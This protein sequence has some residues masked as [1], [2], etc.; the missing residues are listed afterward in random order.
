MD[1]FSKKPWLDLYGDMPLKLNPKRDTVL[2]LF[3]DAAESSP[4]SIAAI[5]FD[6]SLSYTEL[7]RTSEALAAHLV[8]RGVGQGDRVAII[9]QNDPQFLIGMLAAWKVGAVP[10]PMNPMYRAGE[11]KGLFEDCTP[12]AI[13][14]YASD[15]GVVQEAMDAASISPA[16]IV[17]DPRTYQSRNDERVLPPP[18]AL[19]AGYVSFPEALSE[20]SGRAIPRL[21]PA[22]HEPGLL[23]YTSGTTGKPK[24]A[25]S[26]HFA[27]A[28]NGTSLG[29][30]C[31]LSR[32]SRIL[33]IAPL[34][35][36]TGIVCH[37]AAAFTQGAALIL[38]YR[39]EPN[40]ML[41]A[42][43]ETRPTYTI[44]AITA[45]IALMNAAGAAKEDFESFASVYSGG[46]PI[47]PSV[48][49]EFLAR[50]GKLIHPGYGMTES[51][52]QSVF[53]PLGMKAPVDPDSGAL[54]IGIPTFN[55]E[56]MI[57]DDNGAPVAPGIAGELCV[58]GP[59]VMIGYWN[60]PEETAATLVDG[61]LRSGDVA[62]MDE[63]GW[64]YLVDRKKDVIIASGFKVWPR[65]VED[66]LYTHPAVRE[67]AVIGIPDS[68]RGETVKAYVSFKPG[69]SAAPEELVEYCRNRLAS[70]KAPRFVEILEDLPKTI[71][72]KIQRQA[73]RQR[74]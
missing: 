49:D 27:M 58:R 36:I 10:V 28:F 53:C 5:Y 17:C 38:N 50:M 33:G 64:F 72:G 19:P 8:G 51:T 7:D 11:L 3:R 32:D 41:D 37:I 63:A 65:E 52:S 26:P 18:F 35:H 59:Q 25:V 61:W 55:T 23:L 16:M 29:I 20:G 31:K 40:S 1:V 24:G 68:Y 21:S 57:I 42:I 12:R 56:A 6:R 34:F 60:K 15:C 66:V 70:Y 71:T 14:C 69:A 13:I 39:F 54:S 73:L 46:A 67:A 47:P 62:V 9:L 43:R 44:G 45:L 48:R 74:T 2:D 22:G 4:D 30:W